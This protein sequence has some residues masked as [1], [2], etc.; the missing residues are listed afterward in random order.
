MSDENVKSFTNNKMKKTLGKKVTSAAD[1]DTIEIKVTRKERKSIKIY[2]NYIQMCI[3]KA[4]DISEKNRITFQ[5]IF[6]Y[7][8]RNFLWKLAKTKNYHNNIRHSLSLLDCFNKVP[9]V[10]CD[11]VE[12][13]GSISVK[14]FWTNRPDNFKTKTKIQT[15]TDFIA[16]KF[17]VY[18]TNNYWDFFFFTFIICFLIRLETSTCIN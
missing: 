13:K 9:S 16:N 15:S 5:E 11:K 3:R 6:K 18:W 1:I 8:E 12:G 2:W 17:I 4:T 14:N 10:H 7:F